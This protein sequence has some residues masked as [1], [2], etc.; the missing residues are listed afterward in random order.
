VTR[1]QTTSGQQTFTDTALYGELNWKI[2]DQWNLTGGMTLLLER[3][4][5]IVQELLQAVPAT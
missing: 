1:I 2:T 3:Q 4:Q 5:R